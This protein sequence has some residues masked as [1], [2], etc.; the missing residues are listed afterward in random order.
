MGIGPAVFQ[1][2]GR[3]TEHFVPG[4]Y[5]R[6]AAIGGAGSGVSANNGVLVGRARGGEPNRLLRFSS[7]E[8][9]SQTLVGGD[10]LKAVAHF[11]NP[12][13]EYSPQAVLAMVVNGNT[14]AQC[15]LSAGDV[16]ILRLKTA[17]YGVASNGVSLK[18][19]NGTNAGT[20]RLTIRHG[21]IETRIDNIGKRSFQV[22]CAE[23]DGSAVFSV[24]KSG[25]SVKITGGSGGN[26]NLRFSFEDYPTIDDLVRRL[27]GT[28]YFAVEL[29]DE[30]P[31][32]LSSELDYI[33]DVTISKQPVIFTSNLAALIEALE[34]SE[35]VGRGNVEKIEGAPNVM[36]YNEGSAVFFEGAIAGDFKVNDWVRTLA[37]LET[38]NIQMIATHVTDPDVH[39]LI[40]NHCTA[41]SN[42]QNRRERTALLGGPIGQTVDEAVAEARSLNNSLVSYCYPSIRAACPLTGVPED[43]PASYFACKLLGMETSMAVNEPLTWKNVSVLRFLTRLRVPDMEMLI[44][45]GVLCGGIT[46]DNRLAV[47]RAMT[48][49]K[50]RQLQLCERSMVRQDL[51]MNRDLRHQFSLA[52]GRPAIGGI[53]NANQTLLDAARRWAG[54]GLIVPNGDGENVWGVA[55][56]KSGDQTFIS[57]H[58]NLTAPQ[59]FFFITA[60]NHVYESGTTVTV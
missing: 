60:Y 14:Q 2:A 7:L 4:A 32:A 43:L 52:V 23:I 54:E 3:R 11:F 37:A 24:D 42:V 31:G 45:G 17:G 40:S 38:E 48:T 10:L 59:N 58:R 21:E 20:H 56:R 55:I 57:F 51:F 47:I 33:E 34:S 29:L 27:N 12:S 49:H 16:D 46:D 28:G 18:L 50:G 1:T 6:S 41:M 26:D 8:D 5:S 44:Q 36:P 22:R 35:W 9:A 13:P 15:I 19:T 30:E 53:A 39:A 25:V